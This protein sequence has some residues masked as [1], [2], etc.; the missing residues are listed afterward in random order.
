VTGSRDG[1]V[2]LFD[3][4]EHNRSREASVEGPRLSPSYTVREV[5]IAAGGP[6]ALSKSKRKRPLSATTGNAANG[7]SN[8]SST[9]SSSTAASAAAAA[10]SKPNDASLHS[11]QSVTS[12]CFLQPHVLLTAGASTGTI[13]AF[14]LRVLRSRCKEG[15]CIDAALKTNNLLSSSKRSSSSRK[16]AEERYEPLWQI[17]ETHHSIE[18][19]GSP[20]RKHAIASLA[21]DASGTRLLASATN[22][23]LY[24]YDLVVPSAVAAAAAASAVMSSSV[25]APFLLS[26]TFVGHSS[27]SFYVKASFSPCGRFVSAGSACNRAFVWDAQQRHFGSLAAVDSESNGSS[28][29]AARA[30]FPGTR[31]CA[32]LSGHLSDVSE[33]AW[34]PHLF[35]AGLADLQLASCSDDATVRVWNVD[36]SDNDEGVGDIIVE[37]TVT[38]EDGADSS[39][40]APCSP[41][42][43]PRQAPCSPHTPAPGTLFTSPQ[44]RSGAGGGS[45]S[46]GR[47]ARRRLFDEDSLPPSTISASA[48]VARLLS[49]SA[50]PTAVAAAAVAPPSAASSSTHSLASTTRSA[51]FSHSSLSSS[52]SSVAAAA[53]SGSCSL[54]HSTASSTSRACDSPPGTPPRAPTPISGGAAT[55]SSSSSS[56]AIQLRAHLTVSPT[57]VRLAH[58]AHSETRRR[59]RRRS[60]SGEEEEEGEEHKQNPALSAA[61][62]AVGAIAAASAAFSSFRPTSLS[63]GAAATVPLTVCVPVLVCPNRAFTGPSASVHPAPEPTPMQDV[64]AGAAA[65]V[66]VAAEQVA[67][68]LSGSKPAP[69]AAAVAPAV[70]VAT[71]AGTVSSPSVSASALDAPWPCSNVVAQSSSSVARLRPRVAV[72]IRKSPVKKPAPA[73]ANA[74][75]VASRPR[76]AE[77]GA[78]KGKKP[79][80]ARKILD[81][82]SR[83]L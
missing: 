45:V 54:L 70:P 83:A 71:L 32:V 38:Q 51:A 1:S 46:S 48:F 72:W 53:A 16:A 8:G 58:E 5:Q 26:Q 37:P 14:D 60:S 66:P 39:M 64:C 23:A 82:F 68:A 59:H 29:A 80:A 2:R 65:V 3:I 33:T 57:K 12:L 7:N 77:A 56:L 42:R 6:S 61:A 30:S 4:R 18:G 62:A 43:K 11:F 15:Q 35:G 27:A 9:G 13:K 17:E 44:H 10:T 67:A 47:D 41:V 22:H 74:A 20:Y 75:A 49:S 21:L 50:P 24:L 36:R 79:P 55:A 78:G 34:N 69:V 81:F 73:A 40:H 19:N 52:S 25:A 31:P 63:F 76:T 28:V